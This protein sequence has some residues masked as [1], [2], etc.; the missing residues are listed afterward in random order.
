MRHIIS[1]VC[2]SCCLLPLYA[3]DFEYKVDS[4]T[5]F[6]RSLHGLNYNT[7]FSATLSSGD[8]APFWLTSNRHGLSSIERNSTYVRASLIR[9]VRNDSA[10]KWKLGYGADFVL[11]GNFTSTLFVQQLYAELQYRAVELSVGAKE[12]PMEMKNNSLSTGSQTLGINAR[13]VPQVRIGL[14]EYWKVPLTR[15]W[16]QIKG[17]IA[18]G[19]MTDDRWQ[20]DFTHR[21]SRYA[22]HVLYHSKA[23]Y[24]RIFNEDYDYPL[25]LEAGLEM[26]ALFGGTTWRRY[27]GVM[28][29]MS[30]ETGAKAFWHAFVPGGS[31]TYE[32]DAAFNNVEGNQLGSWML[33]VNYDKRN[34]R[35]SLYIDHFFEDHSGM[36]HLDYDGYGFGSE[37]NTRKERRY[38]LYGFKDMMLGAELNLKKGTW[39]RDIVAEYIYTKYQSGPIYHDHN[40]SISDHIGG[41]DNYYNHLLYPGWQHWGQVIGNPLFRSPIYNED[42]NI[43]VENN[44]FMAFHLAFSGRPVPQLDYRVLGTW[45]EGF[46]SYKRPFTKSR[47]QLSLLAE[48]NYAFDTRL[49]RG[50]SVGMALG[51]DHGTIVGNNFGTM[52]NI[53]KT[54]ILLK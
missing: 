30:N 10:Y 37:W 45:Q 3:Q 12:R 1:I 25:S 21:Q 27:N 29:E 23:G 32:K 11:A 26:A 43:E 47:R 38:L 44:R 16:L 28:T 22:D 53:R 2:V 39:L 54:G 14:P 31:D 35:L 50:W 48:A 6:T 5:L 42:G 8:H 33:R 40:P 41:N 24:L 51:Y 4:T 15:G 13:P 18:Y 9:D 17:H 19:M 46:G 49:L 20:H 52:F 7:E 36:F 34:W